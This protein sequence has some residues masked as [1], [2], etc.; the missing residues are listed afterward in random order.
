MRNCLSYLR[1]FPLSKF[2]ISNNDFRSRILT[3]NIS[4]FVSDRY[5]TFT[6][7]CLTSSALHRFRICFFVMCNKVHRGKG[8]STLRIACA[9]TR[10]LYG[11]IGRF[12]K[13]L[14][15]IAICLITRGILTR[16][17]NEFLRLDRRSPF[18]A[19]GRA[20]FRTLRRCQYAIKDRSRLL[21]ILVRVIR[22]VRRYVLHFN[23]T[24]GFLGVVGS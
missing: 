8:S 7:R 4:S 9:I 22:S 6:I 24:N 16:F 12:L 2:Y 15:T 11:V 20:L 10:I 14:R 1:R 17:C 19:Y 21:T 23:R 13:R 18:G 5:L 3:C